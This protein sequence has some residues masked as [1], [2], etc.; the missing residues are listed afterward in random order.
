MR[1]IQ[2]ALPTEVLT[3]RD[4]TFTIQAIYKPHTDAR[5]PLEANLGTYCSYCEVFSSDLEVEHII[6]QNQDDTK[7][8]DWDNFLLS[9]GRCNGKDNKSNKTVDLN[10][11]Y[12][13]HRDNTLLAFQYLEGGL[14]ILNPNLKPTQKSKAQETLNLLGLDKYAGNPQCHRNDTRWKHRR[15]AWEKADE[16][17]KKW[18]KE[19]TNIPA[20]IILALST[21]FF[22]VWFTVFEKHIE[23][24]QALVEAFKGTARDCF[25]ANYNP[26]PRNTNDI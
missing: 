21:G 15:N 24:R 20:I 23:V 7:K 5:M 16:Y 10:T 8:Y 4:E 1:P 26:I 25:D 17:L 19:E 12:F 18:E 11:M 2:K 22:S 9:C 14:V 6:S 3:T 13:P